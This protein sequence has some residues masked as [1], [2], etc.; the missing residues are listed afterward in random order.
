MRLKTFHCV[1]VLLFSLPAM[2]VEDQGVAEI[3][4]LIQLYVDSGDK[5]DTTLVEHALLSEARQFI[6]SKKGISVVD[7]P[8]YIKLL[9]AKRIGGLERKVKI[10]SID[11]D[12]NGINAI[13]KIELA[14]EKAIFYQY[15]GLCK[16][17]AT[18][19]EVWRIVTVLTSVTPV[20]KM[21]SGRQE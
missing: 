15:V 20:K 14:S 5:Q 21:V 18:E 2:A 4:N 11:V 12:A 8:L 6:P 10:H 19:A 16:I 1:L 3:K 13:A 7:Q 17:K 9:A